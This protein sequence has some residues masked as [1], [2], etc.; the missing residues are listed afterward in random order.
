MVRT[1][2][3]WMWGWPLAGVLAT[4]TWGIIYYVW[5]VVMVRTGEARM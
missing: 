5:F 2:A 4:L 1:G 3:G